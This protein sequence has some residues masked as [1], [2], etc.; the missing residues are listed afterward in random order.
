M[1]STAF[2]LG[3]GGVGKTTLSSAFALT[4]ARR[5]AKVLIASL[6]PAHN[7]GDALDISLNGNVKTVEP[8]LDALEV[9]RSVRRARGRRR[10]TPGSGRTPKR[11]EA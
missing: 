3:K 8:N 4:L 6:D 9:D 7:L 5:G 11:N 10:S 1:N 2:F